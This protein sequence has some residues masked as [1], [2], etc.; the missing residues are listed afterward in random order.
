MQLAS[1]IGA[2]SAP[3]VAK[4][5]KRVHKFAPFLVMGISSSI[6]GVCMLILRETR[7]RKTAE[8]IENKGA[9][10]KANADDNQ[11]DPNSK[12]TKV[13]MDYKSET[14]STKM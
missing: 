3:W 2:A 7:G 1:R 6:A 14:D 4:G 10:E 13:N 5:L 12:I 8:V 11:A 9:I